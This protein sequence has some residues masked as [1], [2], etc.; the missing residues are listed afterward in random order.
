MREAFDVLETGGEFRQD[1]QDTLGF[2][3]R[4][5]PFRNLARIGVGASNVSDGLHVNGGHGV[6][7]AVI[8]GFCSHSPR[9][10]A[11]NLR[12]EVERLRNDF[13]IQSPG[14]FVRLCKLPGGKRH[15]LVWKFERLGELAQ[16]P[17]PFLET[18]R[19]ADCKRPDNGGLDPE[20]VRYASGC[21]HDV[22]WT[23][24]INALADKKTHVSVKHV[25]GFIRLIVHM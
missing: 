1:L 23:G 15:H 20:C 25:K 8:A 2:M 6:L 5:G 13:R 16:L 7:P 9:E 4:A 14:E 11:Q 10:K 17:K 3:F 21:K 12:S 19:C 22:S 24:V 18:R